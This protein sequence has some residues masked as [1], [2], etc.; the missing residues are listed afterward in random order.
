MASAP[1]S[2][3]QYNPNTAAQQTASSNLQFA[4]L[5]NAAN[6]VNTRNANGS[7]QYTS[8]RTFDQQAYDRAMADWQAT[9]NLIGQT[10]AARPNQND[11]YKE[12]WV[13]EEKLNPVLDE[14]LRNQQ[15]SNRNLSGSLQ[16]L[17]QRAKSSLNTSYNGPK[18]GDYTKNLPAFDQTK[19]GQVAAQQNNTKL[20]SNL[21]TLPGI[22]TTT[23]SKVGQT[24]LD[25]NVSDNV[26]NAGSVVNVGGFKSNASK[27][28]QNVNLANVGKVGSFGSSSRID[29]NLADDQRNVGG[30]Q[31]FNSSAKI[32][33]NLTDDMKNVGLVNDFSQR[34]GQFQT[35][36]NKVNQNFTNN[37]G[38]VRDYTG[39]NGAFNSS[40]TK[41]DTNI[42]DN[43]AGVKGLNQ[44]GVKQVGQF[45]N[46][47]G[48]VV[49]NIGNAGIDTNL[50][51]NLA[52]N[53]V[54]TKQGTF[55]QG[56]SR[57][58]SNVPQF[59]P[60]AANVYQK[61][62]FD[63]QNVWLAP[64]MEKQRD[65]EQNRLALQGLGVDSEASKGAMSSV[66]DSQN[67]QLN[68]LAASSYASGADQARQNYTT[69]LAGVN[70]ANDAE[71]QRYAQELQKFNT[72]QAAQNQAFNQTNQIFNQQNA[73]KQ[74]NFDN[75][76]VNAQ[77]N[78]SAQNQKFNQLNQAFANNLDATKTNQSIINDTNAARSA[79][80][81]QSLQK[82]N[83]QNDARSQQFA[84][85]DAA[86][87][88]NLAM[89]QQNAALVAQRNAAQAQRYDQSTNNFLLNNQAQAQ[90]FSQ[91]QARFNSGLATLNANADIAK[92]NNDF[93]NQRN[94]Q[95]LAGF[96]ANNQ[97]NQALFAQDQARAQT[98]ADLQNQRFN[99]SITNFNTNNA[100]QDRLFA[101]DQ[102][103][104]Q[105]DADLQ[106][107]RYAQ[108]LATFNA[109]NQARGQQFSQDNTAYQNQL[110][111]SELNNA[112]QAQRFGQGL[113]AFQAQNQA[114]QAQ[115]GLNS[116][117]AQVNADLQ[118]QD[119]A[120]A[121]QKQQWASNNA[122]FYNQSQLQQNAIAQQNFQN[123]LQAQAAN[124]DLRN[125]NNAN[126]NQYL[127]DAL[128]R[129][130]ADNQYQ[131]DN[132][133]RALNEYNSLLAGTTPVSANS[134][135]QNFAQQ[136]Q[137][138]GVDYSSAAA[139]ANKLA[140]ER[141]QA[142]V[143]QANA[144]NQGLTSLAA[145]AAM[146]AA[147]SS[148]E[149]L[150]ENIKPIGETQ[151][152]RQVYSWDWNK[153]ANKLGLEGSSHGVLAQENKDI[154]IK[155]PVT[156]YLA[157]DYGKLNT[158]KKKV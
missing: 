34:A 142:G 56:G 146:Y 65:Q 23:N 60:N 145:T 25:T 104:A 63:A 53:G 10:D 83:A 5:A 26:K 31:N 132:R 76:L 126:R 14:T 7:V 128:S 115:A 96:A 52:A 141:Y 106:Q 143:N 64:E 12:T 122:N 74:Q 109:Q 114:L 99:Q 124:L 127:A 73:A 11:F 62:A 16:T 36:A 100:A 107:Q 15:L 139:Q 30:V 103:R 88:N 20:V 129:F 105:M 153:E 108:A 4:Q 121:M 156:G 95:A 50:A 140:M 75:N 149:R 94:S 93:Q 158:K 137:T 125:A 51:D 41:L 134:Q 120:N 91:D 57:V 19:I 59:D 8:N 151:S 70:A 84:Q 49:S 157:V 21:G 67:R 18:L 13:Q 35:S 6:K 119:N 38:A 24:N 71:A 37:A 3:K 102:A 29:T 87:K 58:Q 42:N 155:D 135:Y 133:Y 72:N 131:L 77:L 150:K 97:A 82:F 40:G 61:A 79:A 113:S 148:D 130:Q 123:K 144:T 27:L 32:D 43:F 101:Q 118:A 90:Q 17:A 98:N 68:A 154:A 81:N 112:A 44:D 9:R 1:D 55:T 80:F 136:G 92:M 39:M 2:P 22:N 117:R 147:M 47:A 85:D 66:Y 28:D 78:N 86:Y 33:N 69:S 48:N 110:A 45:V 89:N 111:G 152:G 54:S 46:N 138:G 116:N